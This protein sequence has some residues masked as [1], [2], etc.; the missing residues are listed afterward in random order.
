ML[1]LGIMNIAHLNTLDLNLLVVLHVVLEERSATRA[2]ARLGRTQSAVSHA[3]KRLR[4]TLGDPIL[5]RAGATM[6]PTPYAE[7]L[8][9]P[10]SD[11]LSGVAHLLAPRAPFDPATATDTF[12]IAA[13]D[14]VQ[15][16]VLDLFH[17]TIH[18]QAP[19]IALRVIPPRR[20]SD[21]AAALASGDLD[22][23]VMINKVPETLNAAALFRDDFI[24]LVALDHPLQGPSVTLHDLAAYPQVLTSPVGKPGG[25]FDAILARHGLTRHVAI[26][27]PHFLTAVRLVAGTHRLLSLPRS[28]GLSLAAAHGLRPLEPDFETPRIR[29]WLAWHPRQHDHSPHAWLRARL[30]ELF[31]DNAPT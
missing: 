10:L 3:L 7:R 23:T 29:A 11:L 2:A 27:V 9:A 25:V 31:Q 30:L 14:Y 18:A 17:H 12:T 8:Q 5:V 6:A 16:R 24:T 26:T 4:D 28:I 1:H 22:L 21:D 15:L 19:H 20:Y 13:S